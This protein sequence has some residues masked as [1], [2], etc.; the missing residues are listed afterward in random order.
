MK[1]LSCGLKKEFS[2]FF[3]WSENINNFLWDLD[4]FCVILCIK[5]PVS[6]YESDSS[7][8]SCVL[9]LRN[10]ATLSL[11][12]GSWSILSNNAD[13][14]QLQLNLRRL[15]ET[16]PIFSP[17]IIIK[18][19]LKAILPDAP[20]CTRHISPS[21]KIQDQMLMCVCGW[22]I[23]PDE[24]CNWLPCYYVICLILITDIDECFFERTCDH[25]CVNSP[26]GFQCLCN[27]GYTMYGLAHC[28]G[29]STLGG[30]SRTL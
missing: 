24:D 7:F 10:G 26:G 20:H 23:P 5:L 14:M 25:T 11:T 30:G 15:N 13:L 27:K 18:S 22:E 29:E 19:K 6:Q 4:I 1:S 17:V 3:N 16:L 9:I 8:L 21:G 2:L 12:F 28:G